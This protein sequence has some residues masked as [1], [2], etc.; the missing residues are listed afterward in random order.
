[1]K[2]YSCLLWEGWGTLCGVVVGRGRCGWVGGYGA[3][4]GGCTCVWWNVCVGPPPPL[5]S[6]CR[7]QQAADPWLLT[8]HGR[9][10]P[11]AV[12]GPSEPQGCT[13]LGCWLRH[14]GLK[15]QSLAPPGGTLCDEVSGT[16][17]GALLGWQGEGSNQPGST[18]Q[19]SPLFP[20]TCVPQ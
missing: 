8:A 3:C 5:H 12:H 6:P 20:M 4:V 9:Q 1:M 11:L 14:T 18:A 15:C 2:P 7:Q 13:W 10:I 17:H 19:S 16:E